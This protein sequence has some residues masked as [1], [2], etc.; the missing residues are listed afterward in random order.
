MDE[1]AWQGTRTVLERRER[2]RENV[3][4]Y[5]CVQFADTF[6]RGGKDVRQFSRIFVSPHSLL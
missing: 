2:E 4:V 1:R 3:C 6:A 5:V